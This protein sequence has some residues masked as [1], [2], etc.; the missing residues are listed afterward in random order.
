MLTSE[1]DTKNGIAVIT[2]MRGDKTIH[3]AYRVMEDLIPKH[4]Q[5]LKDAKIAMAW[6]FS[7]KADVDGRLILGKCKK[8]A[9]IDRELH[10]FDFVIMLNFDIW[11][12]AEFADKQRIALVDH[13]LCHAEMAVDEETGEQKADEAGRLQWRMRK[14]DIEEFREIVQRHGLYKADLVDFAK[15]IL[16][17][18]KTPLLEQAQQKAS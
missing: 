4:H 10:G 16:E 17:K 2:R 14:H 6:N 12:S 18:A 3:P 13:E 15:T 9:P 7:W 8:V 5:H 11:N 1:D